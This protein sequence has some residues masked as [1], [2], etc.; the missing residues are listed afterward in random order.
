MIFEVNS[1]RIVW[2]RVDNEVVALDCVAGV[3]FRLNHAASDVWEALDSGATQ[4]QLLAAGIDSEQLMSFITQLS[5]E[6]V[7]RER[8]SAVEQPAVISYAG[9]P[10]QVERFDDLKKELE[11]DPIHDVDPDKGWAPGR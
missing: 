3:Y 9:G 7:L 2:D 6:Q 8:R 4:D 5:D 1:P 10:L 11:A